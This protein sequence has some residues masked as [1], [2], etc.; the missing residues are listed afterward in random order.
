MKRRLLSIGIIGIFLLT[1]VQSVLA[2][3][4]GELFINE[5]SICNVSKDLT[6]FPRKGK[7]DV[8]YPDTANAQ[9]LDHSGWIEIYNPSEK[10]FKGEKIYFSDDETRPL[11]YNISNVRPIPPKSFVS[12]WF[13]IELK[14]TQTAELMDLDTDGGYLSIASSKGTILDHIYYPQQY[15]DVSYGRTTDGTGEWKY[16]KK[17][18][19]NASNN[20]VGS[21][22]QPIATPII[23]Q[24]SG[25]Y[26]GSIE[27][28]IT[29]DTPDAAIYYT[30][31]NTNPNENKLRY[32]HPITIDKTTTL[33]AKSYKEDHLE[34]LT[35][36]ATYMINERKPELP[37]I[38]VS[39]DP[40]YLYNDTIGIYCVGIKGIGGP[41][42][43]LKANYFRDWTRLGSFEL[44]DK[45]GNSCISRPVGYSISGN[46]S[47]TQSQKAFKVKATSKF[48]VKRLDYPLFS[49]KDSRR[50]KSILLRAGG[51]LNLGLMLVKDAGLQS[52]ADATPLSYQAYEPCVVYLNGEYWGLYN[53]RE[54]SNKHNVYSNYGY[55]NNEFD[56]VDNNWAAYYINGNK[57][58]YKELETFIKEN[59]LSIQENYNKIEEMIDIDN[60]IYYM[61]I[62]ILLNN[63]DWPKGNQRLF[64]YKGG[65]GKW[66]WLLN[67]LDHTIK[68][69][70]GDKLGSILK[71]APTEKELS[72]SLIYHLLKNET[73]K[74]KYIE[75]QSIVAGSIYTPARIEQAFNKA[76]NNI[77]TEFSYNIERW[78]EIKVDPEKSIPGMVA[79]A[80][81]LNAETYKKLAEHF[82]L[83]DTCQLLITSNHAD[84][85]LI[86]NDH[87]IPVLP[88]DGKY[89]KERSIKLKAP[90]YDAYNKFQQWEIQKEGQELEIITQPELNI[91]LESP[92]QIVARYGN[93]DMIRRAGLYINEIS[94]SNAIFVDNEFKYEDWFEICNNTN[95]AIDLAGYY[96]SNNKENPTM[97][98]IPPDAEGKVSTVVPARGHSIVWCSKKP[99]RG[100][101]HTN[102]KLAKEGGTLYL[103]KEEDGVVALIDSVRYTEHS[104]YT[105][106]GRYPDA[107][108]TL[109][110]FDYP[111]FKKANQY[112]SYNR[113]AY[114]EDYPLVPNGIEN[115]QKNDE[116]LLIYTD[117]ARTELI[118]ESEEELM[119]CIYSISGELMLQK[120]LA[121]AN[122]LTINISAF[123][124]GTYI[125][126]LHGKNTN[127]TYKFAK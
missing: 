28:T 24:K 6:V 101:M 37:T 99:E 63:T 66:R 12:Y 69:K 123:N 42:G 88:Y 108:E 44:L 27:V 7:D 23:S 38:F 30:L 14:D 52:L 113:F 98:K 61:S 4:V 81:G 74:N 51:N 22:E 83:G 1:L 86:F 93:S 59:D 58:I 5:I 82:S 47:R 50:Y 43:A 26:P 118:I 16:L 77:K 64:F 10:E 122:T 3:N 87:Q 17:T 48:G 31:D 70:T 89:F 19:L 94:A 68:G 46:M 105:S 33:K 45:D 67:D 106:F 73:F 107:S 54:R 35:A 62:E 78:P 57:I 8:F 71:S 39:L 76:W 126:S 29:C 80:K 53:M 104:D 109:V 117:H 18:T 41:A 56:F 97:C 90:L 13:D 92:T 103:S 85:T 40:E 2:Q 75:L 127:T 116:N 55:A 96:I 111:S 121:N 91:M 102:F 49:T 100:A 84:V 95:E 110:T 125:V 11:K 60:Y 21:A 9:Y 32:I 124:K 72:V 36:T 34:G 15:A 65:N 115:A 112:S 119:I 114:I 25:F 20:S 79:N 120:Q